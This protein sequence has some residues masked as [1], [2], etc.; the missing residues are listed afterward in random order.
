MLQFCLMLTSPHNNKL[1]HQQKYYKKIRR[2][3]EIINIQKKIAQDQE[4]N[5]AAHHK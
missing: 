5:L 3:G 1:K 2:E 4:S